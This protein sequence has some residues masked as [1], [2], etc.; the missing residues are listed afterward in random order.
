MRLEQKVAPG[1][2]QPKQPRQ[3]GA[4]VFII[5]MRMLRKDISLR[6]LPIIKQQIFLIITTS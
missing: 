6:K 5:T 1:L 2:S 4:H 3:I